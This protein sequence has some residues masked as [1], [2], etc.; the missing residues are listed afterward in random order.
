MTQSRLRRPPPK[1]THWLGGSD[2]KTS[3]VTKCPK[4]TDERGTGGGQGHSKDETWGSKGF[5]RAA[6]VNN[7]Y[8]VDVIKMT[9]GALV[10]K[11]LKS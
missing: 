8:L 3:K 1:S 9:D 11:E 4:G 7:K 6:Q 5:Y 10:L 2:G